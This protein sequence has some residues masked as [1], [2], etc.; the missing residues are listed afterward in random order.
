MTGIDWLEKYQ[1]KLKEAHPQTSF[2]EIVK[3]I[4]EDGILA[5]LA[6]T[7]E[8]A[9]EYRRKKEYD[10]WDRGDPV[11]YWRLLYSARY[12]VEADK[13]CF[14]SVGWSTYVGFSAI[15][16]CALGRISWGRPY[17]KVLNAI[18]RRA[19][20][21]LSQRFSLVP[22]HIPWGAV[23]SVEVEGVPVP[24]TVSSYTPDGAI[25]LDASDYEGHKALFSIM[26]SGRIEPY[27]LDPDNFKKHGDS[28]A[29][30]SES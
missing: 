17:F 25:G 13:R 10:L 14:T 6:P 3:I 28:L 2:E 30:K 1:M 4:W 21:E 18:E 12:S 9:R 5:R 29:Q 19:E 16:A 26:P 7:D 24:V 20:Q 27:K 11:F 23:G 22:H 8:V 15:T